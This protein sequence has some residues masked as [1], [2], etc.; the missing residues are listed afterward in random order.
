[1]NHL[2]PLLVEGKFSKLICHFLASLSAKFSIVTQTCIQILH[3]ESNLSLNSYPVNFVS[4]GSACQI[5]WGMGGEGIEE[6]S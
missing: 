3:C 2:A 5:L 4:L 1:M 6:E